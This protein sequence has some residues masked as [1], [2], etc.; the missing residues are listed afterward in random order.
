M[1]GDQERIRWRWGLGVA[2]VMMLVAVFPQLHFVLHRGRDWHGANAVTHPDEVAYSAY[3]A[4]LIRGEPRRYDPYTGRG[5]EA[6][7]AESLF[8]IQLIPA[9]T[10]ALPG[11]WLGLSASTLF[12]VFPVLCAVASSL[13]LFWF[14][15]LLTRD[16]RLSAGAVVFIFCLGTLI[17]RQGIVRYV[18]NLNYL[19][20]VWV[21][22]RVLPPSAYHL[23]FLRLYQPAVAFPLF[24]VLC[25]LVWRAFTDSNRR[26]SALYAALAG[27]TFITLVFSYFYLWTAAAAWLACVGLL[28]LIFRRV[29]FG[30][31]ISVL[32]IIAGLAL[33]GLIGYFLMLSH[34]SA[35]VDSAQ[36][37]VLTHQPDLFRVSEI[38]SFLVLLM[39]AVGARRRLFQFRDPIVLFTASLALMVIAVFNQQVLTGRSLQPIHYEWFI[40]NYCALTAMVLT[41]GLWW[42]TRNSNKLTNK[43]IVT[44]ACLALVWGFGEVWLAASINYY[45][46][47]VND[48]FRP[49]AARLTSLANANRMGGNSVLV[50]DLPLADRVP[51]NAPQTVL[52][53]PR[54]LVFPGV[55]E[56]ENRER[57]FR[58]LYY[59]GY[60]ERR[61]WKEFDKTDWN[62]YAGLF[63]YYRLSRV[64]SGS[65]SPVTPDELR[66][67]IRDYLDYTRSFDRQRASS[68]TLSFVVVHAE[69]QF[70]FQN[71]DRW[72]QR[73]AG[74][75]LGNFVLY[76]VTLR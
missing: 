66:A 6:G 1:T 15:S 23:P 8:S 76:R 75:R 42:R 40:G 65:T 52:W 35:T 39:L 43:L 36:A 30:R 64:V 9:Y 51:T 28:W 56:A 72:Y 50:S 69:D 17:A 71:L 58:Q 33:P 21:T 63:P 48:E 46:N 34:R 73:D 54:M 60:D 27:L 10:V 22:E 7:A 38:A 32:G 26:R 41:A 62:F 59:L 70:D 57:F 2:I 11:R 47:Q 55:S 67:H 14:L 74:E 29:E 25:A 45:R 19:I 12:M 24:F 53:A 61:M 68:P 49:T 16:E 4:A 31:V 20:P 3:T 18:P 5:A 37:L 13:A 44:I